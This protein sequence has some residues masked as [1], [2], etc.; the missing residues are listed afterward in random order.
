MLALLVLAA[1]LTPRQHLLAGQVADALE[2]AAFGKLA[3]DALVDTIL[4]RVDVL[5][6]RDFGL[7]QLACSSSHISVLDHCT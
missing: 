7:V 5:V 2:R 6:A 3:G 1:T 4:D